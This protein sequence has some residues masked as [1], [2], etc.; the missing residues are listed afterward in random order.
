MKIQGLVKASQHQNNLVALQ[1]FVP[2][3]FG[4]YNSGPSISNN[5]FR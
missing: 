5:Y 2:R 1:N 3:T 4:K